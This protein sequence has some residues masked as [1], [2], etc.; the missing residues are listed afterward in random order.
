LRI[1]NHSK[2]TR[3]KARAPLSSNVIAKREINMECFNHTNVPAVGV[4]K[5]CFKAICKNCA[6]ELEH[7]LACS[8]DCAIDV[9]E[10]NQL[11]EKGKIIYGIGSR[12]SKIPS[13][14]V[15]L[16]SVFSLVM[17]GLFLVPYFT[18][19]KVIYGN[20]T[21]AILFTIIAALS[22]YSSKR[23]GIQC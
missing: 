23:T 3:E 9:D 13:T 21:M 10:Y 20:L 5:S 11:N 4:C 19:D 2:A 17:W 14:G 7:G 18:K 15:I 6:M 8:K 12:K 16:W 1:T 22:Y